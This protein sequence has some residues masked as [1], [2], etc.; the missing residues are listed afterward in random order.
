MEPKKLKVGYRDRKAID[1][2][3]N[4]FLERNTDFTLKVIGSCVNEI[5]LSQ[6]RIK[7]KERNNFFPGSH[8]SRLLL[9][10]LEK[11]LNDGSYVPK[12]TDPDKH[13]INTIMFD[14]ENILKLNNKPVV[15]VDINGCYWNTARK[16][17]VISN[18]L[19][20]KG[21]SGGNNWKKARNASIGSL[22]ALIKEFKGENGKLVLKCTYK[23]PYNAVRLD[24]I[25]HVWEIANLIAEEIKD[26]FLFFLTD[27]FFVTK[28]YESNVYE[29]LEKHGYSGKSENIMIE[30]V[31]DKRI[32][33]ITWGT[34]DK[35]GKTHNFTDKNLV[36]Y[37]KKNPPVDYRIKSEDTH[38]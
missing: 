5:Q 21:M 28:E 17:G 26:G 20:E 23:R 38:E 10:E 14:R 33:N 27:C 37:K 29:L 19:Y 32:M 22:N 36:P 12:N 4:R 25:D 7:S 11:R 13:R 31:I 6:R 30:K 15:A 35:I 3:V 18:Q 34:K 16:L 8:L 1:L 24:I 9:L 2:M